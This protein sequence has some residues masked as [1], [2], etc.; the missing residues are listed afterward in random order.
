M[1]ILSQLH[2]SVGIHHRQAREF[3]CY[4]Y[5]H[6]TNTLMLDGAILSQTFSRVSRDGKKT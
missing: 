2:R 5:V 4:F 1:F 3:G 6:A